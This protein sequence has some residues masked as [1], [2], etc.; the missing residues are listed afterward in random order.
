MRDDALALVEHRREDTATHLLRGEQC[1][2]LLLHLLDERGTIPRLQFLSEFGL[3]LSHVDPARRLPGH[4]I[5][6][7]L[8]QLAHHL[9]TV[10]AD[11]YTQTHTQGVGKTLTEQ[12]L[13]T[14]LFATIVVVGLR[15]AEGGDDQFAAGLDIVQVEVLL[16]D[17]GVEHRAV[18]RHHP[19][20]L[21]G[22]GERQEN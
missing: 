10:A 13:R 1:R 9:G 6:L 5:H 3:R 18:G 17:D 15:T 4:H 21:R 11:I 7:A 16:H 2:L 20:L 22:T 8:L 19:F 14:Q 12:E